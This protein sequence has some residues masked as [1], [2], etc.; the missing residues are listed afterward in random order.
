MEIPM[1]SVI[2]VLLLLVPAA[3][4]IVERVFSPHGVS[5]VGLIGKW[6]VFWACGWCWL[7]SGR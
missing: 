7:G 2:V 3:S 1:Y 4:A 5:I 6:Y